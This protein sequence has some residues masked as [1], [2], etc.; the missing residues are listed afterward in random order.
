MGR[1]GITLGLWIVC[2][3]G[4]LAAEEARSSVRVEGDR[5]VL[6]EP[7][8][9][10]G[11]IRQPVLATEKP[12]EALAAAEAVAGHPVTQPPNHPTT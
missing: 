3:S 8:R 6:A 10:T 4:P 7:I 9:F 1:I 2:L 12:V 11:H 5:I